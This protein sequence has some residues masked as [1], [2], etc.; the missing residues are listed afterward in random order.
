[1]DSDAAGTEG[2]TELGS[3]S[4]GQDAQNKIEQQPRSRRVGMQLTN[5]P[6]NLVLSLAT[7]T[8]TGL[9]TIT[10]S[11]PLPQTPITT[12]KPLPRPP[13][14]SPPLP[15]RSP[16][17]Q[18][19]RRN[20]AP[21]ISTVPSGESKNSNDSAESH[22]GHTPIETAEDFPAEA[23]RESVMS[24]TQLLEEINS[25]ALIVQPSTSAMMNGTMSK[26]VP[27]RPSGSQRPDS[28]P[29][30]SP[31]SPKEL[32]E[33]KAKAKA[34][35]KR[36]HALHE[37]LSSERAFA[38]DLALIREVH[39]PLAMGLPA[40]FSLPAAPQEGTSTEIVVSNGSRT[41]STASSSTTSSASTNF[42]S[43]S[44][45]TAA[46]SVSSS[47]TYTPFSTSNPP[48]SP[49]DTKVIFSNIAELAFFSDKFCDLLEEALGAEIEGGQGEDRVGDLFCRVISDLEAPYKQ[50]I[51]KHPTAL[52]R[53][54][55]LTK[56]LP[57]PDDQA[58]E[59]SQQPLSTY[60]ALTQRIAST[61]SHA[62]DLPS[63]LIK[64]VQ[65]LLKY[66]LLIQ[67]IIDATPPSH[68]DYQ[69]LKEAKERTEEVARAVNEERRRKEVVMEVLEKG[70][71]GAGIGILALKDLIGME[72]IG[73]I[74][75]L[76]GVAA[77]PK[78]KGL[79]GKMKGLKSPMKGV[80]SD[81]FD[82]GFAS[83]LS[84]SGSTVTL[85]ST[86]SGANT[87][88]KDTNSESLL[89]LALAWHLD[90]TYAFLHRF[91]N[92][93]VDWSRVMKKNV[94]ALEMWARAFGRVI[95]LG[96]DPCLFDDDATLDESF[97]MGSQGS[98]ASGMGG[99]QGA[100]S[101]SIFEE[102]VMHSEAFDAFINLV[103]SKLLPLAAQLEKDIKSRLLDP[104]TKLV[105]SMNEPRVLINAMN[106]FRPIHDH[107]L[108]TP[109]TSSS[110]K[111][112][113]SPSLLQASS[114]YL[115]LRGQLATELPVF[116]E[117]LNKGVKA[118]LKE[119]VGM[120]VDYWKEVRVK[121][122]DLW[123]MLRVEGEGNGGARETIGI[124]ESRWREVDE[125][126][127]TLP[128][129]RPI[130]GSKEKEKEKTGKDKNKAKDKWRARS[131][132]VGTNIN[133]QW[134]AGVAGTLESLDP[135]KTGSSKGRSS[136]GTTVSEGSVATRAGGIASMLAALDPSLPPH[137]GS[138]SYSGLPSPG[139][140]NG[141]GIP[142]VSGPLPLA[143]RG[144][145]RGGTE[146]PLR[147]GG[148]SMY[149]MPGAIRRDTSLHGDVATSYSSSRYSGGSG[150]SGRPAAADPDETLG[151]SAA[152]T[153]QAKRGSSRSR[154][155][156]QQID[157]APGGDPGFGELDKSEY[158]Q[159]DMADYLVALG[160]DNSSASFDDYIAV[161]EPPRARATPTSSAP[162]PKPSMQP[163]TKS[164]PTLTQASGGSSEVPSL[165]SSTT[166]AKILSDEN[167]R[168]E[169]RD[170]GRTSR[171]PSIRRKFTDS[172]R[173]SHSSSSSIQ[174][175]AQ[176]QQ[177]PSQPRRHRSPS[178]K[179]T[180]DTYFFVDPNAPPTPGSNVTTFASS[181]NQGYIASNG[182]GTSR[183]SWSSAPPKYVC[184][185]V[186]ACTPPSGVSYF[187][188]PFFRLVEGHLYEV[189]H[190]AGHPSMHPKLPLH[191]DDGADCLLLVRDAHSTVG[192][193]LASF[194]IPLEDDI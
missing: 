157:G 24:I 144:R 81:D 188:Y 147:H 99:A 178:A 174:N 191:V 78:K 57:A 64:P 180:N 96:V 75:G 45:S 109:I 139:F 105:Q 145:A 55:A 82:S 38:S 118:T 106:G 148:S 154:R 21:L 149:D 28:P 1:M 138:S 16:L 175:Q 70:K 63:L 102:E 151:L 85:T 4:E 91:A 142:Y 110:G 108:N 58:S 23:S 41:L 172:L 183:K 65:R 22:S 162:R 159:A 137:H 3:G 131:G 107:L 186:H 47:S 27:V 98:G 161:E 97:G 20:I 121:W 43:A 8:Y 72:A 123:E 111:N 168:E 46:T 2:V 120:Q 17:R 9:D 54:A 158:Y 92:E 163:R 74:S 128:I 29:L 66:P 155:D 10:T 30:P 32:K 52:A 169:E 6:P 112:R 62:W 56:G 113:P 114:T 59:P 160:L 94:E 44:S 49:L 88:M 83:P 14:V 170:R 176:Q 68:S 171:K 133:A 150:S 26:S 116:V 35:T 104:M 51:T 129:V 86:F 126:L 40:S 42:S 194:L 187:S 127:Q 182:N 11:S 101:H 143:P 166:S 25:A 18:P 130:V 177:S 79:G 90:E 136:T 95:G 132:S 124:W 15:P 165:R 93:I 156:Q 69:H 13:L 12:D 179:S 115:A 77:S 7:L 189:L 73:S 48:F 71:K 146:T 153:A 31:P 60:L 192:W 181:T 135:T 184:Q 190:E 67:A 122:M 53:L 87:P 36:Q 19:P 34:M 152:R 84:H 140:G 5:P 89:V 134:S 117:L 167:Q 37:L 193:A 141:G 80:S 103:R 164:M 61:H 173:S 125:V 100:C 39:I 76:V 50:Y 185:V 33:T 119:W